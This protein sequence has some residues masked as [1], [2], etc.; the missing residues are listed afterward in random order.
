MRWRLTVDSQP[1]QVEACVAFA[2]DGSLSGRK[3]QQWKHV[4]YATQQHNNTLQ[5]HVG[6]S[7]ALGPS[8][9]SN[10][11]AAINDWIMF[12]KPLTLTSTE[13]STSSRP[14]AF[15]HTSQRVCVTPMPSYSLKPFTIRPDGP[16]GG[17]AHDST[18]TLESASD[19]LCPSMTT[20]RLCTT[21]DS[22]PVISNVNYRQ[23]TGGNT[24][25]GT[26]RHVMLDAFFVGGPPKPKRGEPLSGHRCAIGCL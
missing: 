17:H 7:M 9:R 3:P 25:T 16:A 15:P 4:N 21:C 1:E 8:I 14:R 18:R 13:Y 6:H 24:G 26:H 10:S 11:V 2:Q 5:P 22:T 12:G 20:P 19:R 23:H